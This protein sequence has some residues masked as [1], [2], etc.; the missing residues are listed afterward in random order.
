[1]ANQKAKIKELK[2]EKSKKPLPQ[3]LTIIDDFA[4]RLTSCMLQGTS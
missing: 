2:D 1:M 3:M 4:D